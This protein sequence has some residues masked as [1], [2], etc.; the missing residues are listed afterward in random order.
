M[1]GR[2]MR[3]STVRRLEAALWQLF[4]HLIYSSFLGPESPPTRRLSGPRPSS[5]LVGKYLARAA[6]LTQLMNA[7]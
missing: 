2:V 7:T 1:G 4:N 3:L 6:G 5:S